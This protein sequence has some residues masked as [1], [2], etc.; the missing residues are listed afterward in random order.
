MD[1]NALIETHGYWL[2]AVGCL[3]EGETIL[4]LAGFAAHRGHLD[5]V[6]VFCIAAVAGFSGDEIFFWIG[7][8]HGAAVLGR[9][10]G[11]AARVVQVHALL[12]RYRDA[13]V[14]FVRFA[15]GLR[16][17]GPIII[18]MSAMPAL[19]FACFNALG[20]VMWAFLVGGAGWVFGQAAE[21]LLGEVRSIEG[22]LV[23]A[24]L[25]V[26]GSVWGVHV[27]RKRRAQVGARKAE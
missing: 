7:R 14:V 8:R 3:L 6:A 18:G 25:T 22:W 20:A 21:T 13:L 12:A 1:L 2:L 27:W 17:A 11:L 19:R 4:L 23:L 5:P 26:A 24:L 16:A 9:W 10:P 15:Y